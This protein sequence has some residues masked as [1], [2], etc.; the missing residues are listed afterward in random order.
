M[1]IFYC[2]YNTWESFSNVALRFHCFILMGILQDN[3]LK[4]L[5]RNLD[6]FR[7]YPLHCFTVLTFLWCFHRVSD[8]LDS[9]LNVSLASSGQFAEGFILKPQIL[10]VNI[11]YNEE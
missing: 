3:S 11:I 6:S 1:K 8:T 9:F 10:S 4:S 2:A 7:E 5:L